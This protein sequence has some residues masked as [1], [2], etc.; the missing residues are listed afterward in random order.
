LSGTL[1]IAGATGIVGNAAAE[2]FAALPG[3]RG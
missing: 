3:V 2:H 1:L